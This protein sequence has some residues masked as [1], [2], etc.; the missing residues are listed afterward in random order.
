MNLEKN[1]INVTEQS[2]MSHL[3]YYSGMD[4]NNKKWRGFKANEVSLNW[5]ASTGWK[6]SKKT[7]HFCPMDRVSQDLTAQCFKMKPN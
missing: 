6:M 2:N 3:N 5:H 4:V 7:P 1:L